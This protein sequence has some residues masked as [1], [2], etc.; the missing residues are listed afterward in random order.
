MRTVTKSPR[1]VVSARPCATPMTPLAESD[2]L[3]G[4]ADNAEGGRLFLSR[5]A[6]RAQK[7]SASDCPVPVTVLH[8]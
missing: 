5:G 8:R 7:R 2:Y 1:A 6:T 4:T 3:P